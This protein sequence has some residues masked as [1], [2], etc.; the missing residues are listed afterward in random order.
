[1]AQGHVHMGLKDAVAVIEPCL[2]NMEQFHY[3]QWLAVC[4]NG[5]IGMSALHFCMRFGWTSTPG[6]YNSA[7]CK[8][9]CLVVM[10]MR[11]YKR[12]VIRRAWRQACKP[13]TW[14]HLAC[15]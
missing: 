2:R 1:M 12:L 7:C 9:A 15:L 11:L 8:A 3:M 6:H 4:S 10:H 13:V 14:S 5:Y